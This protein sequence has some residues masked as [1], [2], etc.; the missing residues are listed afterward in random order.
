MPMRNI[1]GIRILSQALGEE[2]GKGFSVANL[3]NFRQFYLT[4]PDTGKLYSVRSQL[5]W[6]HWRLVLRVE[7]SGARAYEIEKPA[8]LQWSSRGLEQASVMPGFVQLFH[9]PQ[10]KGVERP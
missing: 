1:N 10:P 6:T 9:W 3:K 4:F 7:H 5:S 2:F 8:Y